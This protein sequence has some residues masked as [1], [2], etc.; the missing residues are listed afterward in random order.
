MNIYLVYG[1]GFLGQMLFF[2]RT[3]IQW[4]KSENEGEAVSPVL[5]WKISLVASQLMLF[6][7]IL[8]HDFAIMLG[9]FIVYYIYVRNLQLKNAWKNI[10]PFFRLFIIAVPLL[11][12]TWL[13]T[14]KTINFTTLF[15]NEQIP[16]WLLILGTTGQV[17]FSFRFVYQWIY[18]EKEKES[19]LPGVFWMISILGALIIFI[20]AI[21]RLDP[22]LFL[23]NLLGLFIYVRNLLLCFG[24]GSLVSRMNNTAIHNLSKKISDK[25]K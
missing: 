14:N 2:S 13:C 10:F 23:S 8:R 19:V 21:F 16:F 24:R 1:L 5:F 4:F 3:I 6:Y 11:I 15:K 25:I 22:V 7:G 9:Q 12:I 17:I 18:S 20:Y